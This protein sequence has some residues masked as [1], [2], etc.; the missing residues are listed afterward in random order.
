MDCAT[1]AAVTVT[2]IGTQVVVR[3]SGVLDARQSARLDAAVEEVARIVLH[4]VVVDLDDVARLDDAGLAFLGA[5][6][7]R[8]TVRLL[9]A[10]PGLRHRLAAAADRAS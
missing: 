1:P 7:S 6:Q 4:R 9:N 5:L 8:W 2:R 10:P 3:V